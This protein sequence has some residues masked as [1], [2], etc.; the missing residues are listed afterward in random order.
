MKITTLTTATL[1][2]AFTALTALGDKVFVL[3]KKNSTDVNDWPPYLEDT[4]NGS[5]YPS[6]G[7]STVAIDPVPKYGSRFGV[8]GYPAIT[9]KP[10]LANAGGVYQIDVTL[11]TTSAAADITTDITAV[12]CTLST[13]RSLAFGGVFNQWNFICYITNDVGVTEPEI[14]FTYSTTLIDGVTAQEGTGFGRRWYPAPLRFTAVGDPCVLIPPP[15]EVRGPLVAGQTYVDV[16]GIATNAT[17]VTVYADGVQIGIKNSSVTGGVNRVTTSALVKDA[18]IVATQTVNNQESCTPNAGTSGPRVGGGANPA[19]YVSFVFDQN[20]A[21]TGPVGA[22]ATPTSVQ[23]HIPYVGLS[24]G[25]GTAPTGGIKVDPNGC[26]Q[27]VTVTPGVDFTG[28]F[29]GA[30]ALPDANP[31]AAIAALG[32]ELGDAADTGPFEIYIDNIV[33]GDVVIEDFESYTNG[34]PEVLF[35]GPGAAGILGGDSML[36][37]RV[38]EV[39]TANADTGTKSLRYY[40]QFK[41]NLTTLWQRAVA[42]GAGS[43]KKYPVVDLSKPISV[44]VLVLPV[45]QTLNKLTLSDAPRSRTAYLGNPLTL[46]V[47]AN[48][49]PPYSYEWSKDGNSLGVTTSSY[50]VASAIAGDAGAYSV[51]VTDANCSIQS[52]PAIISVSEQPPPPGTIEITLA[53]PN[54][55]LSWTG[56]Y[57]LQSSLSVT[58]AFGDVT[59]ATS[60]Y[61]TGASGGPRFFRLRT[62]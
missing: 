18:K 61:T 5:F 15:P 13:N 30:V 6:S 51:L 34:Q 62:P 58:G 49:T 39:T 56:T 12:G 3:A 11:P 55:S 20:A 59:G 60:P 50:S 8:S 42:N 38:S 19:I 44:R 52:P 46:S 4:S 47:T 16:P 22:S 17:G 14:T 10:T 21:L 27:T 31:Y 36:F 29:Q 25:Y 28:Q 24:G 53:P 57:V 26:W 54:V 43:D 9:V 35:S 33:N 32:F 48:G 23:Y 7:N 37:P 2:L 41:D 45:G 1:V 40:W